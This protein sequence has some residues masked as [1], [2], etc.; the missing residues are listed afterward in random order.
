MRGVLAS[1]STTRAPCALPGSAS[2]SSG[3]AATTPPP[4]TLLTPN[5]PPRHCRTPLA[6]HVLD[7]ANAVGAGVAARRPP[8]PDVLHNVLPNLQPWRALPEALHLLPVL[9]FSGQLLFHLDQRSL[10]A[11]RTFLWVHGSLMV[12]RAVAFASTLLPD[13]SR[14]CHASRYLGSCFDL[15]FSGHVVM[16]ILPLLGQ[17]AFFPDTH[18][19]AVLALRACAAATCVL[20]AATRNHYTVDVLLAAVITPLCFNWWITTSQCRALGAIEPSVY[21]WSVWGGGVDS[22]KSVASVAVGASAMS[23]GGSREGAGAVREG[24][25]SGRRPSELALAPS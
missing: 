16:M 14:Q 18:R 15:I 24:G 10:D 22:G 19:A 5:L 12:L 25:G 20:V 8:L 7:F 23:A 6:S 9:Y 2:A 1:P 21:A 11:F 4:L 3:R 13:A 17:A